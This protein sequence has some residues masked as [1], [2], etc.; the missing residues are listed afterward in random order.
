M[1]KYLLENVIPFW[2]NDAID[3]QNGGIFTQITR[4]GKIYGREKSVWFQGRALYI[5]SLIYNDVEKSQKY[6]DIAKVI[7]DFYNKI[8][9]KDG[10][11]PFTVTEDGKPI[12]KR[13]YYFSET[14]AAIGCAE[15]FL[16]TKDEKAK[17]MAETY[18]DVAYDLYTGKRYSQPKFENYSYVGLSPS[19]I[20][21]ATAQV[22]RKLNKEKYDAIA[23]NAVKD[24]L[25]H[26]TEY[27]LLENIGKDGEFVDTPTGRL[28]NPGHSLEAAW[29]LMAEGIYQKD[30][31]LIN[32]GKK[33]IDVSMKLGL[34][35]GGIISFC[36][37]KGYPPTALEWD[38]K[39]WWP[40]CEG[41]IANRL[42][43]EI[44][45]E[46]K[47]LDWYEGLKEYAFSHFADNEFG[48]WYGYLHYDGSISTDL[49]GNIFKGP[50]HLPRM[51][52]IL[53]KIEKAL[54]VI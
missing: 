46:K 24:I 17:K 34:S 8:T 50:F 44:T 37:C 5:F 41:I 54:P 27:G 9:E 38:M 42:C 43:N 4:D 20:M 23:K 31:S 15:Y 53:D 33:I 40:Q 45:G 35:G 28:V 49:K 6:L 30:D 22:M 25:L 19:M 52:I 18:F 26:L 2:M 39:L 14:F 10:R 12:Q 1:R 21:L 47:Y 51:L 3:R 29:F 16:A 36:D 11:L 13:R 32:V 7:F 48:E